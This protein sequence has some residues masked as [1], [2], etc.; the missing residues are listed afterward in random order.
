MEQFLATLAIRPLEG[1][2]A[3][4]PTLLVGIATAALL[5]GRV[6]GDEARRSTAELRRNLDLL[7]TLVVED[8]KEDTPPLLRAVM[9]SYDDCRWA[10]V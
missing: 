6:T 5:R 9:D 7:R 1:L 4:A 2:G 8:S 10:H 3:A